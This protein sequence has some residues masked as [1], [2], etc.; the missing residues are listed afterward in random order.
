LSA[1]SAFR[2]AITHKNR[3]VALVGGQSIVPL[4]TAAPC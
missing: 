3:R 1:Q 4:K 2:R